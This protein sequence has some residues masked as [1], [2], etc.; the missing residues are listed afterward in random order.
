[1]DSSDQHRRCADK[2]EVKDRIC[3]LADIRPCMAEASDAFYMRD[4]DQPFTGR[5]ASST[6][7]GIESA[8]HFHP[9]PRFPDNH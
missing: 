1:L 6:I 3:I 9:L 4:G 7:T 5:A 2:E 8:Q